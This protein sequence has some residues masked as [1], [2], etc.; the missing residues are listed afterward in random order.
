MT[1]HST[2]TSSGSITTSSADASA[3]PASSTSCRRLD[4]PGFARVH[5]LARAIERTQKRD[6]GRPWRAYRELFAWWAG[7]RLLVVICATAVQAFGWPRRGW[8]PS[9]FHHPL[10]LLATWDGLW[11]RIIATRGYLLIPGRQSDP[12]FFPLFSVIERGLHSLGIPLAVGGVV[13]ANLCFL[14][15]L[16]ALYELGRELLPDSDAR[17]AAVYLAIFPLSF[18]FSMAYPEAFV[19]PA[20]ALAGLFAI[21]R[22]WLS[23]S[24]CAYAATLAR[25][26]GLFVII[27]IAA[28]T[29]RYWK[30]STPSGRA[31]SLAA[32][33]AAPFAIATFMFYLWRTLGDPLAWNEAERVWGRA[34]SLEGV[35]RAG[36]QLMAAPKDHNYWLFRDAAFC[37]VYLG[38]IAVAL[39]AR[40]PWTWVLAAALTVLL[41][42]ASG[43]VTSDGRFGL[44]ALVVFWGLAVLGR[45][46]WLDLGLRAASP[47]LLAAAVFVIPLHFP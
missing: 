26:E 12:A 47:A 41:P 46:R 30:T 11:Y 5:R 7:S 31:R 24:V 17:R 42:L 20:I 4:P 10:Q 22:R 1:S 25:P 37:A 39:L 28:L 40:I 33:L 6:D 19:L 3:P 38:L 36:V 8:A 2:P 44:L 18:V 34:F 15:G 23:C 16:I 27:P 9:L 21:R 29:F 45:R 13:L 35:Y 43:S 32:V 14:I